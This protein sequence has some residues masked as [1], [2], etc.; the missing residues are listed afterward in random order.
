MAAGI[1]KLSKTF[2]WILM[3]MLMLGLA[4]FGAVNLSG[5][6]RTVA[7]VGD[8]DV[9]VDAYVREL[10]REIRAVEAQTGQPMQMSQ[11]RELGLDQRALGRLVSLA[12]LNNEVAQLGVSIGDANL[13]KEIVGIQA[14]QGPDGSFDREAYRFQLEQIGMTETEFEEDL[15]KETARTI[16][17]G[18]MMDGVEMPAIMTKALADYVLARRSF[19]VA[20]L[21]QDALTTPIPEPT[22]AEI[23]AYYDANTDRFT[24]P[25]TKKITYAVLSP[26]MLQDTVEIDE[27]ALKRLYEQR[28]DQY[29]QPERRL[30]ERLVYPSEEEATAAMAQLEVGGADFEQLVREREL[31][32]SSV[33]L[34]DVTREDLGEAADAVF[35]AEIDQVV[36]PLPSVFGPALFRVNGSLAEQNV[37]FEDA[38]PELRAELAGERARRLIE[39]QAEDINDML[40]GG[41]TLEELA[42]ETEME[43]GKIDW[44]RQSDDGI[45][46][47]DGFRQAAQ[48]V[49]EDD[50]P[51]IG[52]LEDGS[53]FALRLDEVLPP[54]PEPLESARDR[55]AAA[56]VQEQT[57]KA[58]EE[59]ANG[60]V[61]QLAVD[62][63]FT[64][65]G[66]PFRVEN[67]LTRTAFLDNV[68]ADFMTQIFE[69]EPNELRVIAG[70]DAAFIV[71]LDEVL[72]PAETDEQ[73]LMQEAA[74]AQLNQ[75]LAQNI[76]DIYVRDAQTRAR[77][78]LDQRA[79]NA[80][81]A[82]F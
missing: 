29:Q 57:A 65:T 11:A 60:I 31:E 51:E 36:G 52:F 58:L 6:V 50:F 64:A 34:G 13:Q 4:G 49:R 14:F 21:S 81:Q 78:T 61:T 41:A 79:L 82:N 63:D 72:P 70:P 44:T 8:E 48:A 2:V 69:M 33:D 12:A 54:R 20:T 71:R 45:A 56:W 1:N 47:Y 77:P 46:A 32:L 9:S 10:Q 3:G 80:V 27:D 67:A 19:T 7:Q 53:I 38:E 18:A 35:A 73:R 28:K 68:P 5:T 74:A 24:L 37:S 62:G 43:L 66:L 16:V 25:R 22:D 26:E 55:V 15:R 17:Q 40:A 75:A 42:N 30:V 59:Q 39:S 23:Q 76:F